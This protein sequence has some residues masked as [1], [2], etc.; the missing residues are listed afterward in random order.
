[1]VNLY[2]INHSLPASKQK[3]IPKEIEKKR[4][5]AG[6][7]VV[8]GDYYHRLAVGSNNLS[9]KSVNG[10]GIRCRCFLLHCY[11]ATTKLKN[12]LGYS[13]T[14]ISLIFSNQ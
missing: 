1:M 4:G 6:V 8:C 14:Q 7:S 5:F 2:S 13:F 3:E 12:G 11:Y 10:S 9:G